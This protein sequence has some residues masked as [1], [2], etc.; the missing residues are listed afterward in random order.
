ME[1]MFT[2]PD[3]VTDSLKCSLCDCYLSVAP[4]ALISDDGS[5]YKC[6]R[7]S[8]V[9]TIINTRA[10]IYE[11]VAKLLVFPCIFKG[12]DKKIPFVNVRDHEKICAQ[13]STICPKTGCS[14]SIKILKMGQHFKEKHSESFHTD[15]F[16]IKNA[17]AYYNID[18]LEKDGK[19]FIGFFDFDEANFGLSILSTDPTDNYLQYEVKIKS[20]KCNFTITISNQNVISFVERE[21]CFKCA[22]GNCKSKFHPYRDNRKD[23]SRR[24]T[25]KINRDSIK[26]MFG[27]G[28]LTYA[29]TIDEKV[30]DKL[31]EEKVKDETKIEMRDALIRKAKKIFLQLLEC[32]L[33]K[34]YMAPP[35]W[36]CLTGH[37]M[38]NNCKPKQEQ[39]STCNEKIENT[40]NYT[41]EELSKK[42]ELPSENEKKFAFKRNSDDPEVNGSPASKVQKK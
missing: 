37:T 40:R 34:S 32:P 13:R 31:K 25:T 38:C 16:S 28:Q 4:I 3:A 35:I 8:A 1:G 5:Q 11:N 18:V 20:D 33:C 23:I 12:C 21:H 6:G 36:Q 2:P 17:Y 9:K 26:K 19:S 42:V 24:M 7:C 39:C 41:L 22:S 27:T 14:D 29:I 10:T 30:E 15:Y